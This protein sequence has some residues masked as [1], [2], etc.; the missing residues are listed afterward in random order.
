MVSVYANV[1]SCG[2]GIGNHASGLWQVEMG[3][4][5]R[6]YVGFWAQVVAINP[7]A[8]GYSV[9]GTGCNCPGG[10]GLNVGPGLDASTNVFSAT[11]INLWKTSLNGQT[12]LYAGGISDFSDGPRQLSGFYNLQDA[13]VDASTNIF[14]SDSTRIRRIQADGWTRTLA[15]TGVA[16]Y[17]D[18]RGSEAQFNSSAGLCVDTN[19]NVYVADTANNCI[20]K[21][22]PD[23]YGIGIPDSWQLAN[24]GHLGID[25]QADPDHDGMSNFEEF[26]AGTDPH[27]ANSALSISISFS[28][29]SAALIRW[30]SI[31]GKRYSVKYSAD[32]TNWTA[33]ASILYGTG[34]TLSI[35]DSTVTS[36]GTT[37][38]YRVFVE[39]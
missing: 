19:G 20:R 31:S 39:F 37:R 29:G 23:T 5:G 32:L 2:P 1:T 14:L 3:P 28:S 18:G 22:S 24:F 17:K 36:A 21:I 33:L 7:D 11:G 38:F 26:W 8:S 4:D 35:S 13:A 6:L 12:E 25:P 27:D 15:G 16:G 10:W 9:A 30:Q 34:S